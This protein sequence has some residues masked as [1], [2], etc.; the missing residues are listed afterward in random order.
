M[1]VVETSQKTFFNLHL[2]LYVGL[3]EVS[4]E[5]YETSGPASQDVWRHL[6]FKIILCQFEASPTDSVKRLGVL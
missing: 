2:V 5:A 4:P 1:G 3:F 6:T